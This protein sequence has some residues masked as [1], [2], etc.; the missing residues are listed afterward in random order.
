[1]S[2]DRSLLGTRV[3]SIRIRTLPERTPRRMGCQKPSF[4]INGMVICK[5][6]SNASPPLMERSIKK[7]HLR[8]NAFP[9]SARCP[10][11]CTNTLG[12]SDK[13]GMHCHWRGQPSRIKTWKDEKPRPRFA[14]YCTMVETWGRDTRKSKDKGQQSFFLF[15]V[16][17]HRRT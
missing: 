13:R 1:M 9:S 4:Q 16:S 10:I 11:G 14:D 3:R 2:A 15:L 17:L 7:D 6:N 5:G 8:R 12:A